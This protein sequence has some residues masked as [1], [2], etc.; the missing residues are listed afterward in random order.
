MV[1]VVVKRT[2]GV[3]VNG[4]PPGMTSSILDND[5]KNY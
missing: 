2:S 5:N 1:R 4:L 3:D